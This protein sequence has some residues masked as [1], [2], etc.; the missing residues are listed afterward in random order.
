[1]VKDL[2]T[3][4]KH[5]SY[6]IEML[7]FG[8][9]K[10]GAWYSSPVSPPTGKHKNMALECFLLHFRNLR[11]FLCPQDGKTHED[12]IFASDFLDKSEATYV[13]DRKTLERDKKRL[14]KM[15]AHL[16][17]D[18]EPFIE[19]GKDAWPVA[20]MSIDM[21]EQLEVFLGLL[22]PEM[23]SWFPSN[24]QIS[25]RKS[26]ASYSLEADGPTPAA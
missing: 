13:A 10:L 18:R 21:L 22:S 23:R 9:S 4:A 16:S 3:A 2:Q 17:Y 5:V 8:G 25:D 14:N 20:R 12:D 15:L 6:E 26:E 7:M 24:E 11:D 19:S 1:M